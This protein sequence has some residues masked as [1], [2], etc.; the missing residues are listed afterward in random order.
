MPASKTDARLIAMGGREVEI[1]GETKVLFYDH[2]AQCVMGHEFRKAGFKGGLAAI[3]ENYGDYSTA[4]ILLWSGL[5]HYGKG[6]TIENFGNAFLDYNK[7]F[8]TSINKLTELMVEAIYAL[9]RQ[10]PEPVDGESKAPLAAK[11]KKKSAMKKSG[12][13]S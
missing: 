9:N 5:I 8:A 7:S 4:I 12:R 1:N 2:E 13:S 6:Q 3:G 10:G 11:K